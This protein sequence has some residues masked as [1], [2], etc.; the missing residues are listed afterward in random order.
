MWQL[1]PLFGVSKSAVDRIIDD[2]GPMFPPQPGKRPPRHCP[3]PVSG[4]LQCVESAQFLR[5]RGG[6]RGAGPSA[7][8]RCT[9]SIRQWVLPCLS[10]QQPGSRLGCP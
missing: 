8:A 6:E 9:A 3:A 10:A 4:V 5:E 1:A 7:A 2:L